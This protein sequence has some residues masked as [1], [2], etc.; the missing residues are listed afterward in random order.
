METMETI[1]GDEWVKL[2]EDDRADY[3]IEDVIAAIRDADEGEW[4]L[5]DVVDVVEIEKN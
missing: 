1:S 5:I 3:I 4:N 2:S